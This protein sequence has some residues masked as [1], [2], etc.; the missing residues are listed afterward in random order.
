[1][2]TVYEAP[3]AQINVF[4]TNIQQAGVLLKSD[5]DTLGHLLFHCLISVHDCLLVDDDLCCIGF[6]PADSGSYC[7]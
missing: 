6:W 1:M 5:G 4:S 3:G 7:R 2:Q